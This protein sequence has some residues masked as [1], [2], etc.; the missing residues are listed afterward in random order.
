MKTIYISDSNWFL[1][2][3]ISAHYLIIGIMIF[4]HFRSHLTIIFR[5]ALKITKAR[6]E[7]QNSILTW[8]AFHN[9]FKFY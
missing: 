8:S 3:M 7:S 2:S 5:R 9:R 1:L 6:T 4:V